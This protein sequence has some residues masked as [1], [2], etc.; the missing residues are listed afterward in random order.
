MNRV[1]GP[2]LESDRLYVALGGGNL[3]SLSS[4][5]IYSFPFKYSLS[6]TMF[7]R[8]CGFNFNLYMAEYNS[9]SAVL[10]FFGE[11]LAHLIFRSWVTI[12]FHP[13]FANNLAILE[14]LKL[15]HNWPRL[16]GVPFP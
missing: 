14:A 5:G 11:L 12:K 10:N 4:S 13:S 16:V 7:T 2:E 8:F 9:F 3:Y 1:L 15:G 6:R